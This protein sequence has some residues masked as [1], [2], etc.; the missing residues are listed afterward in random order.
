MDNLKD[1]PRLRFTAKLSNSPP[2]PQITFISLTLQSSAASS[3]RP[4]PVLANLFVALR[5]DCQDPSRKVNEMIQVRIRGQKLL[6]AVPRSMLRNLV[7]A[8]R[9]GREFLERVSGSEQSILGSKCTACVTQFSSAV[10]T[11]LTTFAEGT[12]RIEAGI[13]IRLRLKTLPEDFQA[14]SI[15]PGRSPNLFK[16]AFKT[17]LEFDSDAV[18][19]LHSQS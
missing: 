1:L 18:H 13:K 9:T 15:R 2:R 8:F 19:F 5:P 3:R 10:F 4:F 7:S 14:F 11:I 16:T 12:S 17:A 6:S